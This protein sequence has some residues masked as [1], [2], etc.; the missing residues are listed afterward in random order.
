[1]L[2]WITSIKALLVDEKSQVTGSGAW[3]DGGTE[4]DQVFRVTGGRDSQPDAVDSLVQSCELDC[5]LFAT[6]PDISNALSSDV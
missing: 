5:Q 6:L 4:Y 2:C 1:M 3:P